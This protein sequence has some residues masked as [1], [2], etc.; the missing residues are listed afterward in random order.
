VFSVLA[1][2]SD[3]VLRPSGAA[4]SLG[5]GPERTL[6]ASL[7]IAALAVNRRWRAAGYVLAA[8]SV[9]HVLD[10]GAKHLVAV[11][12]PPDPQRG[13]ALPVPLLV[14]CMAALLVAVWV[15]LA[16]RTATA[17]WL[18]PAAWAAAIGIDHLIRAVPVGAGADS[19]PSGHASNTMALALAAVAVRPADARWSP[20][21]WGAVGAAVLVGV[22]RVTLGFH[23][24]TDVLAGWILAIVA[25]T[26]L[27][28]LFGVR[29]PT[30]QDRRPLGAPRPPP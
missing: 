6:V 3:W 11:P 10:R 13:Y 9:V 19:F 26:A 21:C 29:W 16:R 2:Q 18:V 30:N 27:Q 15:L 23:R 28:P 7:V 14:V 5:A 17:L 24:P 12:R 8:V 4:S 25:T 1:L 20:W 22:S